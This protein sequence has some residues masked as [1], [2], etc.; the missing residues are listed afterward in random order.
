M[1]R[2]PI[3]AEAAAVTVE[4][5]AVEP[6]GEGLRQGPTQTWSIDCRRGMF[7][8]MFSVPGNGRPGARRRG[9][10]GWIISRVGPWPIHSEKVSKPITAKSFEVRFCYPLDA[11][12]RKNIVVSL[13]VSTIG[14]RENGNS[15]FVQKRWIS[16]DL[17]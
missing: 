8:L 7:L 4:Y 10:G 11:K 16:A 12:R 13:E 5:L 1:A 2:P 14:G 17:P 6:L 9:T 15:G 3:C